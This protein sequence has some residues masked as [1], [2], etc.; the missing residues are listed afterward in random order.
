MK[1]RKKILID[2][3]RSISGWTM[4]KEKYLTSMVRHRLLK[5]VLNPGEITAGKIVNTDEVTA[6]IVK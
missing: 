4:N 2:N 3:G 6:C 1:K 5:I